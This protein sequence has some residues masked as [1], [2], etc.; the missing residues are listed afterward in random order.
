MRLN[1]RVA[2]VFAV[3]LSTVSCSGA[4]TD[5][6][7]IARSPERFAARIGIAPTMS[8]SASQ[9]YSALATLGLEVTNVRI[10]LLDLGG[11]VRLDT[12]IAFPVGKDTLSIE[13]PLNIQGKEQQFNATVQLR[14]ASG[15]VQ[16]SSTQ[17]VT[18]RDVSLPSAPAAAIT[19]QYVGPGFNAKTVAVS[20]SDATVLPGATQLLIATATDPTGATVSDL[21]VTWTTSDSSIARITQTG[22]VTATVTARGP[23]GTVTFTAKA[24]TG[25]VGTGRMTVLPQAVRLA[26][27]SGDGQTGVAGLTLATPLAVEVQATDGRTIAGALVNFRAVTAGGEVA[28]ASATTDAAGRARTIM[29]LGRSAGSYSFEASSRSL[30]P[31][32]VGA[33]ATAPPVGPPTQLIPLTPLPT[34]FRVGVASTQ[35][36]SAQI[37]DANGYSVLLSGVAVTAT[38]VVSPGGATSSVTAVSDALGIISMAIPAFNTAGSVL[39]TLTSP[40]MPNLPYGTFTI[41][42]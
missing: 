19:L 18:A 23:R 9:A 35:R 31:V 28:S 20:P 13:L 7:T 39:I 41:A 29:V 15:A 1:L 14:D 42:P 22:N 6:L 33:T 30:A 17:R 2:A 3:V 36:L 21:I 25:V 12:V 27:I 40:V 32:T 5:G 10:L 37:A 38:M 11:A 4:A 24:P 8:A 26:V 34:S 16:F